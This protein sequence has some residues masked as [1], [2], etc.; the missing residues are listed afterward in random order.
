[1]GKNISRIDRNRQPIGGHKQLTRVKFPANGEYFNGK[2]AQGCLTLAND[3]VGKH[4]QYVIDHPEYLVKPLSM[5]L[6]YYLRKDDYLHADTIRQAIALINNNV[7][8]PMPH[9]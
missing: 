3:I 2:L 5:A 4:G 1:M 9:E 8:P 6:S 7:V